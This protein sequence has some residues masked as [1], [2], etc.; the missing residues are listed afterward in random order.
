MDLEKKLYGLKNVSRQW[1]SKLTKTVIQLGYVQ[2]VA[3][4]SLFIRTHNLY[5]TTLL[6]YVDDN[7]LVSNNLEEIQRIKTHL[8]NSFSIKDLATLHFFWDLK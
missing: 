1:N 7:I 4:H 6:I 5:F 2:S 8:H 3:D